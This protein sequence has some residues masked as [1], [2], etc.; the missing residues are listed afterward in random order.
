MLAA[1]ERIDSRNQRASSMLARA[2]SQLSESCRKTLRDSVPPETKK[3]FL[4]AYLSACARP[5]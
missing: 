5:G 1:I 2:Y 4:T 3:H